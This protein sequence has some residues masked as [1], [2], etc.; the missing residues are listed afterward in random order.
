MYS[1][2]A[3]TGRPDL[4]LPHLFSSQCCESIFRQFRSMTSAF[5]T[6]TNCTVK[7]AISRVGKIQ[8]QNDII[9][10]TSPRFVYPRL[11]RQSNADTKM[12]HRLPSPE[13][14]INEIVFCEKNAIVTATKLGLI[15]K[16]N[17]RRRN[18]VCKI[19]PYTAKVG[20]ITKQ[21]NSLC[22]NEKRLVKMPDP[23]NIQLKDYSG[24]L[25]CST[26]DERSGY[27]ELQSATGRK[28]IV[29]KTSLCWLLRNESRKVSSDRLLRVRTKVKK[30]STKN[31]IKA[32]ISKK[33]YN[34]KRKKSKQTTS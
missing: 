3:K 14:I 11:E 6:V 8:L 22:V 24:K 17:S 23:R 7:E 30:H 12:I 1:P 5:S 4:F 34:T 20:C 27:A 13:E 28:I 31:V 15:T 2:F 32:A 21:M 9:H 19:N 25:K 16:E 10:S 26:V 33:A 18:T 29:R